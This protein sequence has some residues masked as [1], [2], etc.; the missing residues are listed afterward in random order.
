MKRLQGLAQAEI[1]LTWFFAGEYE[2]E[3]G[4]RSTMGGIIQA[5]RQ[6]ALVQMGPRD[7]GVSDRALDASEEER[8][9]RRKLSVCPE[10]V[11][12][13][14]WYAFGPDPQIEGLDAFGRWP[15]VLLRL[16]ETREAHARVS[17]APF[18][19]WLRKLAKKHGSGDTRMETQIAKKL[20][21]QLR[22]L[23]EVEVESALRVYE[24][25]YTPSG[26]EYVSLRQISR[27][28]GIDDHTVAARIRA[29]DVPSGA[30]SNAANAKRLISTADLRRK[31]PEAAQAVM[32]T[33]KTGP[34]A[35]LLPS[36]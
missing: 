2:G 30:T 34:G 36:S 9:I 20:V 7:G 5:I 35:L 31:W 32:K 22:A 13:I 26:V 23:V 33:P 10:E 1:D 17:K 24:G 6:G 19:E 14:L 4:K 21:E 8:R 15:R 12:T 28:L 3:M 25:G 29:L 27:A 11:V 18:L 16:R